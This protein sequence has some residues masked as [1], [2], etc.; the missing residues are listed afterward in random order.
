MA[1]VLMVVAPQ[2]F[3]DAEYLEPRRVLETAGVTVD[4]ASTELGQAVG[5]EGTKVNIDYT[6][7]DITPSVYKAVIFVGGPGMAK[8]VND[9]N[10]IR[11][12][13]SFYQAGTIV[14]AICIAPV[15]LANAGLLRGKKATS[16]M[17][18][19]IN[20]Q[21]KGANY[22]GKEVEADDRVVTGN[23]PRAATEFGK[24]VLELISK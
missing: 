15:V 20:L 7:E 5:V 17:S 8:L 14:A 9:K 24:K 18:A 3:R 16:F 2:G 23:G 22:T 12:A 19:S 11:L 1:R 10:L 13:L 6:I 21:N 4:V